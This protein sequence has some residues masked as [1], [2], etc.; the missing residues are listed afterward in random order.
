MDNTLSKEHYRL[1]SL[2]SLA[3]LDTPAEH[4]FDQFTL[5][6]TA[7]FG[8]PI[9]LVSLVDG[10]RQWFKSRVGLAASETDRSVS[11]CSHAIESEATLVVADALQ[12]ARFSANA[13]VLGEPH[14]R[15]YAGQPI[16]SHDGFAVGTLCIIDTRP[17]SLT[18]EQ[19]SMLQSLAKLVEH[20]LNHDAVIIARSNAESALHAL[21]ASLD[22]R[23]QERAMALQ[24]KN[25]ALNREIRQRAEVE[26]SLRRS[27]QLLDA[28]LDTVDM[29][30]I[31]CDA[32][33]N[34]TFFNRAAGE[35]HGQLP[36]QVDAIDWADH[37][38]LYEADGKTRLAPAGIPLLRALAG[39]TVKDVRMVIAPR[40]MKRRTVL[41][42]GRRML[43]ASGERMGAVVAIKDIS[44][45]DEWQHKLHSSE[46]MLRTITDNVPVLISYLDVEFRFQFANAVYK[47]WLGQRNADMIG[48]TM[49]AVFGADFYAE[50][51]PSL[52]Q[53]L[54]GHMTNFEA[55]VQRKGHERILNTTYIP[56][57]RDGEVAG[58][59]VLATDST[60]SREHERQL[61][62][63]ANADP[64]TGLPNRRVY[65]FHL[66]KALALSR[67]QGTRLGLM[68]LDLDNF[69]KINDTYGHGAGDAVL[70]EFGKRVKSALRESDIL[71]R[72]AGDEFTVVLE[73]VGTVEDCEAVARK[74]L[75]VLAKPFSVNGKAIQVSVSI[76]VALGADATADSLA[77]EADAALYTS[78]RKGKSQFCVIA[79]A[80]RT[81]PW[82]ERRAVAQ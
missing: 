33:G 5:L 50:R 32:D 62:A 35:F 42:S 47:E 8:V 66:Q 29:G 72:L 73:G 80:S 45:L 51:K 74:I 52:I 17:R 1:R 67:R 44:D 54:A 9:A 6:A 53:A 30:V 19:L 70:I 23:V 4:R 64:L 48:N 69:K 2:R 59:Y 26:T 11:F 60:A 57:H 77:H 79:L 56:H 68:Y 28:V 76:G 41:A 78:K 27:E 49:E 21:N 36:N 81:G 65:E 39:E 40:G 18:D 3:I 43:S 63:L 34:L 20:E 75:D 24:E 15:F 22:K 25:D 82:R 12:D 7:A 16:R 13:L 55:K 46:Q 71:A 38:N 10:D 14:I 37:Y 58:I 31:A 61:L